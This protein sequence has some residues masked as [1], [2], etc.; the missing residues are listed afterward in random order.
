MT[1]V[2]A[3]A[4]R[5]R[6]CLA[7]VVLFLGLA[8]VSFGVYRD[9]SWTRPLEQGNWG[10][11]A[12]SQVGDRA[13]ALFDRGLTEYRT[14]LTTD[15]ADRA[16]TLWDA[17]QADLSAA[18]TALLNEGNGSV[19][20]SSR[21]LAA[22]IQFQLGNMQV[23][24]GLS[25]QNAQLIQDGVQSYE[26]CLRLDPSNLAARYNIELLEQSNEVNKKNNPGGPGDKP[27]DKPGQPGNQPG[28]TGAGH[29]HGDGT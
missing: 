10:Q 20:D 8:L 24:N 27:G 14:A 29:N 19:P 5:L 13:T 21:K 12:A 25:Q 6:I 18:Y 7:A 9:V 17:A 26:E 16:Q 15:D 3:H 2:M 28:G 11:A 22:D 1:K 23:I 4:Y